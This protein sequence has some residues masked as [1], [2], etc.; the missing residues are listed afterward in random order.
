MKERTMNSD[1]RQHRFVE[2][3]DCFIQCNPILVMQLLKVHE[4]RHDRFGEEEYEVTSV[5][6]S[7]GIIVQ[8]HVTLPARKFELGHYCHIEEEL[9]SKVL[10]L[11][12]VMESAVRA[13]PENAHD[14]IERCRALQDKTEADIVALLEESGLIDPE[15]FDSDKREY[16]PEAYIQRTE[17]LLKR[18]HKIE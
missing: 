2:L 14:L 15:D 8:E 1:N 16:H 6:F 17:T 9:F 5:Y 10:K 18:L 4:I 13:L 11:A 7:C 3:G 12:T